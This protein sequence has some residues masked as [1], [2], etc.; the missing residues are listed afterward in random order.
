MKRIFTQ[1]GNVWADDPEAP[2]YAQ[3]ADS[4]DIT[5][6]LMLLADTILGP[7]GRVSV[8]S[9]DAFHN[10]SGTAASVAMVAE[11][12]ENHQTLSRQKADIQ[13][14]FNH[15]SEQLAQVAAKLTETEAALGRAHDLV[16]AKQARIDELE[17]AALKT[18]VQ[19]MVMTPDFFDWTA[20]DAI[21]KRDWPTV[22]A[23]ADIAHD[24][25]AISE[26]ALTDKDIRNRV[27]RLG[28]K[29]SVS[30]S[31][32]SAATDLVVT[33]VV[34]P[35]DANHRAVTGISPSGGERPSTPEINLSPLAQRFGDSVM[36]LADEG[37]N[38][39]EIA[40][41]LNFGLKRNDHLNA[42]LVKK[43]ITEMRTI[44]RQ[45]AAA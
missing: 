6:P 27:T 29:R 22:R 42:A 31:E 3:T 4:W 28:L 16:A 34:A 38:P 2:L 41:D 45:A 26:K 17:R 13:E 10:V 32:A 40:R 14:Q 23:F 9:L 43:I 11:V 19:K 5:G 24:V 36:T 25:R 12:F 30:K 44:K 20:I 18:A 33:S 35:A 21:L 1:N 37:N 39:D 15:L 8:F 7:E